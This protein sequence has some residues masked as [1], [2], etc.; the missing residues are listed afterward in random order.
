MVKRFKGHIILCVIGAIAAVVLVP[1]ISGGNKLRNQV[2]QDV[3]TNAGIM[4]FFGTIT[5][6]RWSGDRDRVELDLD[7]NRNGFLS[8]FV[9]GSQNSGQIE[10]EWTKKPTNNVEIIKVWRIMSLLD[11]KP[12]WP[13]P[14]Q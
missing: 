1:L 12:L 3:K 13:I 4:G 6:I 7:G 2:I 10:V 11:K 8:L 9:R 14:A 5:E